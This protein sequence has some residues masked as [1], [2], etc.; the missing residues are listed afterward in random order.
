MR[1]PRGKTAGTQSV[2]LPDGYL[3]RLD[4]DTPASVRGHALGVEIRLGL[5]VRDDRLAILG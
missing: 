4:D 1:V 3:D 2:S 5:R